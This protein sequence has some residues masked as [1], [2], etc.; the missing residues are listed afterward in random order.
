MF[1]FQIQQ[2]LAFVSILSVTDERLTSMKLLPLKNKLID[3]KGCAY[4]W[5]DVVLIRSNVFFN[6]MYVAHATSR[7]QDDL[8]TDP[9]PR[10]TV[11]H[12]ISQNASSISAIFAINLV[13]T[14]LMCR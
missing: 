3:S 8:L 7:F 6:V 11:F 1:K 5:V 14:I 13:T 10:Q 2:Y 9:I 12:Y 4:R